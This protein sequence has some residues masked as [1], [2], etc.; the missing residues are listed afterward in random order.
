MMVGMSH[1]DSPQGRLHRERA[2]RHGGF[3]GAPPVKV[4]RAPRKGLRTVLL[5]RGCPGVARES[6]HERR[7][8]TLQGQ[9]PEGYQL[10]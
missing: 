9:V 10:F 4:E 8:Q 2:G 6:G 1:A 3:P 5:E 7:L